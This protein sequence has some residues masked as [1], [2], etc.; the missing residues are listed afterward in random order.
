M[1]VCKT[2]RHASNNV[3]TQPHIEF[4]HV[5]PRVFR[6]TAGPE[7]MRKPGKEE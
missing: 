1:C 5:V 2:R 6:R 3:V 4:N 7:L